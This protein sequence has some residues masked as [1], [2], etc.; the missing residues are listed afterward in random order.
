MCLIGFRVS[1]IPVILMSALL[2]NVNMFAM[3]LYQS[4]LPLLGN[5]W[6]IG[7]YDLTVTTQPL[8]G[9]AYSIGTIGNVSEMG[10]A[11]CRERE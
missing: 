3:L 5:Q 1:N 11:L 10:R 9:F 2:A 6:W 4:N 8:A 7:K